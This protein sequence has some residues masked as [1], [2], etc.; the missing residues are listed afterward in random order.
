MYIGGYLF[1]LKKFVSMMYTKFFWVRIGTICRLCWK[2][3]EP[4]DYI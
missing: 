1:M 2:R 4:P 3:H